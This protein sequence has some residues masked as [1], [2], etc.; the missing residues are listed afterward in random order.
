[1]KAFIVRVLLIFIGAILLIQLWIFSSLVW[2]RTHEVDTTMF[3]RIDYWSDPSEPIIHEWLDY[4]DISDNFKHAILAG[5]DAKFI[6][7][8]GF[9]W[10]GIRFALERNNEQGEVVAGGSTVSQQLAKTCS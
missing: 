8:H 1:M 7:H 9:D 2:W 5:E 3:M 4:D 6:H 10:D